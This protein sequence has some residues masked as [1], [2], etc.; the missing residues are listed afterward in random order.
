MVFIVKKRKSR[1]VAYLRYSKALPL[2]ASA[3]NCST[4]LHCH[5]LMIPVKYEARSG[6][7]PRTNTKISRVYQ[8][9]NSKVCRREKPVSR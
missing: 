1:T 8:A 2:F 4:H 6:I 3:I 7:K 5:R 9:N